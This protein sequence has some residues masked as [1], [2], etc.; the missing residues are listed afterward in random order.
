MSLTSRTFYAVLRPQFG[1]N[2]SNMAK[3][4]LQLFQNFPLWILLHVISLIRKEFSVEKVIKSSCVIPTICV[5]VCMFPGLVK[6]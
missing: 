3:S 6:M 4:D 2:R 5:N 1:E